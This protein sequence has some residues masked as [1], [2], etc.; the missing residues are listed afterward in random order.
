MGKALVDIVDFQMRAAFLHGLRANY[1]CYRQGEPAGARVFAANYGPA[2]RTARVTFSFLPREGGEAVFKQQQEVPLPQG[3]SML[4]ETRWAPPHFDLDLYRIRCTLEIDRKVVD[5]TESGFVVWNEKA[6]QGKSAFRVNYRDNYIHDGDRP[7]FIMGARSFGQ[8]R[9]GQQGDDPLAW[10]RQYQQMQDFGMSVVSP[11]MFQIYLPNFAWGNSP[12]TLV[13]EEILRQMDAQAQ[14]CQRHKLIY[15]PCIFFEHRD[16]ALNKVDLSARLA[17]LLGDRYCRVPGFV[18]YLWDD[19]LGYTKDKASGD[20]FLELMR[21]CVE[22]LGTNPAGRHYITTAET[23][24]TEEISSRRTL[25]H[26]T[27]GHHVYRSLS[28][29]APA[30][31]ADLRRRRQVAG[32][33]RV[34]PVALCR[35]KRRRPPLPPRLPPQLFRVGL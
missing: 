20:R 26:F 2:A 35:K 17:K 7:L 33:R 6:M 28:E 27:F 29:M 18:F 8:Q 22:A 9:V 3:R 4:V 19:G 16:E 23:M 32:L 31:M 25:A 24:D 1:C 14:L 5:Q 11:V 10:D 21:R 30:R 13:P 15:A 34:L 12:Q